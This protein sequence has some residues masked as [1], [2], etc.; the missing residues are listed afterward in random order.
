MRKTSYKL[1]LATA[2]SLVVLGGASVFAAN[3]H[4]SADASS[5][6][7][8][9]LAAAQLNACQKRQTVVNN[10]MARIVDRGTKQI[11][12][13]NTIAT[14]TEAF[15]VKKGKTVANYVTLVAAVDAAKAKAQTDLAAMKTTNTLACDASNP[16]GV[17]SAFQTNLKLEIADLKAY[18]TAVKNLIVAV[19]SVQ[20]TDSS[21]GKATATPLPSPSPTPTPNPKQDGQD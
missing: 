7:T 18:K 12:V 14:R 13:F 5:Q 11:A 9:R 19:K 21:A 8:A 4:A 16:K 17:V 2:M 3:S 1:I 20:G 6:G 10:I 15:Y